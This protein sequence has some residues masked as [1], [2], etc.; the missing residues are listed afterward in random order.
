M[1][2]YFIIGVIDI[3]VTLILLG[4]RVVRYD[5]LAIASALVLLALGFITP[6]S[7]L[8]NFASVAVILLISVMVLSKELGESG[9][10]EKF[11]EL[12]V[13]RLSGNVLLLILFLSI[14][15]LSGFV[16]D[17][18]I[19]A[20]FIPLISYIS[21]KLNKSSSKFLI[22]LAYSAIV[23]GRYTLIGTTPNVILS[24]LWLSRYGKQ[25]GLFQFFNL[26]IIEVIVSVIAISL[27][28]TKILPNRVKK[29]A[30]V[31]DFKV[32]DY[33]I[34]AEV[35]EGCELIGKSVDK[36]EKD[37]QVKVIDII[38]ERPR[39]FR[40]Y[41]NKGDVL[42]IRTNVKTLPLLTSIKGLKLA[43]SVDVPQNSQI[44]EILVPADS[45]VIGKSISDLRLNERYNVAVIGLAGIKRGWIATRVS[46]VPLEPGMVLLVA[47]K[48]DD[49]SSMM[50][51]LLLVPLYKRTVKIYNLRKGIS[52]IAGIVLGTLLSLIGINIALSF[53]LGALVSTVAGGVNIDEVYRYVEWRIVVFVGAFLSIGGAFT[54]LHLTQFLHLYIGSSYVYLFLFTLL[55]ANFINNVAAATIMGPL[56][57]VFP[58]PLKAI[59]VIAMA[60]ST[61]VLTPYSHQANLLVFNSGNYTTR[62]YLMSGLV[63]I[64]IIVTITLLYL[65]I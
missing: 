58:D 49:I 54:N 63:L 36:F 19:T 10:L 51:D 29:I 31:E 5:L 40:R 4:L 21:E 34:E 24:Q 43:P 42:L 61:T 52:A 55:I 44:F 26:G 57:F 25:L 17:V 38:S 47:G 62:D 41:I 9:L 27:L 37:N 7:F 60:S 48:D 22:P 2:I 3:L 8:E 20:M 1:N 46:K 14:A 45:R 12:L 18:A 39:I 65:Y 32:S 50:S 6:V 30:S 28:I 13:N 33:I 53:L 15:I 11:G 23:G 16:S 35:E 64:L 56:A 59:T